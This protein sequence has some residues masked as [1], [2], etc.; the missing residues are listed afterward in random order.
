M[1]QNMVFR[2]IFKC[3]HC[4]LYLWGRNWEAFLILHFKSFNANPTSPKLRLKIE[5][6]APNSQR[7][8]S[9]QTPVQHKHKASLSCVGVWAWL[10]SFIYLPGHYCTA[11]VELLL[12]LCDQWIIAGVR[13]EIFLLR[14][15]LRVKAFPCQP[16]DIL[17]PGCHGRGLGL[18][19]EATLGWH[20]REASRSDA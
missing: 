15:F 7:T 6:P 2:L 4:S 17:S 12:H 19:E 18:V 16:K 5:K 11:R 13:R 8:A 20:L 9:Q 3:I 14:V 10:A 1:F